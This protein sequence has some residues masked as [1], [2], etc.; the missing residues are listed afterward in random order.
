MTIK[1]CK[2]FLPLNRVEYITFK[3]HCKYILRAHFLKATVA[4][5]ISGRIFTCIYCFPREG[6]EKMYTV[7]YLWFPAIGSATTVIVGLLVSLIA[8][9]VKVG[10]SHFNSQYPFHITGG[11]H[12]QL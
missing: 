4:L 12:R 6:I 8:G 11:K 1:L 5:V 2:H 9:N 3:Q 7:S 10:L